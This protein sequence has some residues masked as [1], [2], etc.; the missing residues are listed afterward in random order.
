[1]ES[2]KGCGLCVKACP[3]GGIHLH[4]NSKKAI[5]CDFCGGNPRCAEVCLPG[6]LELRED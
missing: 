4:S 6:A 5:V 1:L 2:C 3:Y